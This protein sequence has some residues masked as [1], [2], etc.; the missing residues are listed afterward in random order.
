MDIQQLLDNI[1]TWGGED[2][3]VYQVFAV[4]LVVVIL[5][6]ALRIVLHRLHSRFERTTTPWDDALIIAI[7]PPLRTLFW[8]IGLAF[9]AEI[10]Q[11]VSNVYI[12]EAIGPIR[13]VSVIAC[14]AWFLTRFIRA[15][16]VNLIEAGEVRG[17]ELDHTTADA[18]SRL[19]R[20][21]VTITAVLVT[22]QTLGYSIAGVLAFGGIGGIAV[23]FA[24]KD[25]LSN[26]FGGIMVFLDRPFSVGDWIR[27]S[28]R[29]I[30]GTVEK[31]GWRQTCI[32]T[33]DKRPLYIPNSVFTTIA[34]ENPSR[35]SHRR[36]YETIGVRYDDI[37]KMPAI[38]EDIEKMLLEHPDIDISQTLMVN[39][40]SFAASSLDFF[41]YTFTKT[42]VWTEY[43]QVKQDVL[44]KIAD[45]IDSHGAEIAFPTSTLHMAEPFTL[46]NSEAE[47]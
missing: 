2:A 10:T 37:G 29:E 40:N 20:I 16:E 41:I 7:G 1:K 18:I 19:L 34:V 5:N 35:M 33:F 28:D 39:F 44:L 30:E 23:G 31:I 3:W 46:I 21:S 9:A 6:L 15:V 11:Q 36:I 43:H 25:L 13:D 27:S 42:T 17:K 4:V 8:V 47:S 14:I 22:L 38:L 32:R 26:F 12:F 45:I 24:A